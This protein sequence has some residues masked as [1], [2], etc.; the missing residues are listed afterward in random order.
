VLTKSWHEE[1]TS[2]TMVVMV[3]VPFEREHYCTFGLWCCSCANNFY[4]VMFMHF[5]LG[6]IL[7]AD[8]KFQILEICA[9]IMF[10]LDDDETL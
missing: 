1:S 7:E 9:P 5:T 2:G 3:A 6:S 10:N 4:L 8:F